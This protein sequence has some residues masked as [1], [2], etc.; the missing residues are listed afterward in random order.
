MLYPDISE[1]NIIITTPVTKGD[2]KG[3]LIDMDLGKE[4]NSV[5]SGA[6]HRTGTIQFM[7]I[8]VLQARATLIGTIL[9][10]FSMSLYGCA[11]ATATTEN[12][13]VKNQLRQVQ[14][15]TGGG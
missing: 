2:P 4:L 3:R 9:S 1:N 5:P 15:Q 6:S 13:M 14:S 10:L 12:I 7:A 8:E 11:F